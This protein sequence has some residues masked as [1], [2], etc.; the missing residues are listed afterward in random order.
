MT[1][2]LHYLLQFAVAYAL[3]TFVRPLYLLTPWRGCINL[4]LLLLFCFT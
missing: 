2:L 4:V 3:I 1:A